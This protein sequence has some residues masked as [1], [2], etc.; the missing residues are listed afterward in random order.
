[1]KGIFTAKAKSVLVCA[2]LFFAA[3]AVS[4]GVTGCADGTGTG[5][6][7]AVY[8]QI[9]ARQAAEMMESEVNYVLLD[10]RTPQEFAS[11]HI[12][13]A[14]NIPNESIGTQTVQDLPDKEQLIMVYCRSGN[15]SKQAAE[16]LA[17]LGYT[18][19]VEFGGIQDWDG[20]LVT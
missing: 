8:R 7:P 10:V 20:E 1:M 11:G 12:P 15:R 18:H 3:A 19:V 4:A 5:A 9:T 6:S 14:V 17:R 2:V 16:K 13:G